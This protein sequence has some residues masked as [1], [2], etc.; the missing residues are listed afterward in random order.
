M[1]QPQRIVGWASL[2]LASTS[3]SD[4]EGFAGDAQLHVDATRA[5]APN[6]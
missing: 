2:T 6:C 1:S 5:A 3:L 4:A